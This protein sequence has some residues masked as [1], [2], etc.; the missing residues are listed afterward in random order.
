MDHLGQCWTIAV[1]IC[2]RHSHFEPFGVIWSHLEPFGASWL[3]LMAECDEYLFLTEYEY[4]ILFGFQKSLN[5]EYLILFGIETI[6]IPNTEYLI[7]IVIFGLTMRIPN[8]K[9]R[10][11]NKILE[12]KRQLKSTN[13]SH[14]RHFVLHFSETLQTDIGTGI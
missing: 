12:K 3:Y 7:R 1:A 8:T 13:L 9:Y 5:T 10:I 4:R 11:I 6:R 14:T 2:L